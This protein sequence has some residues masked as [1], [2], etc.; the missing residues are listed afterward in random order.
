[1]SDSKR[2]LFVCTGNTCRSPMAEGIFRKL[3]ADT[4]G[5]DSLGSAGVAAYDGDRISP[6]TADELARRDSSIEDFRSRSVN[7]AMLESATHVFAMTGAHLAMLA[8]QFP[9]YQRKYY[10]VCDF[11][12]ID[13]QVGLDVPDPIGMGRRAYEQV[14]EVFEHAIPALVANIVDGEI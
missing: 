12:E 4:A 7:K 6:E 3:T 2:I 8:G 10:L 5:I 9:E 11:L 14:G 1:M 13:G